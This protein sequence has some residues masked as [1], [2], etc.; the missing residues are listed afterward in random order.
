VIQGSINVSLFPI[1][2]PALHSELCLDG[3]VTAL[4]GMSWHVNIY[5][6]VESDDFGAAFCR[7]YA[8]ASD[9]FLA[10]NLAP[11][12]LSLTLHT[13]LLARFT[14]HVRL[15]QD[16]VLLT[17]RILFILKECSRGRV[18]P[19]FRAW[20]RSCDGRAAAALHRRV[21]PLSGR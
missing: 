15:L 12:V 16:F 10:L 21:L 8:I 19:P 17:Y 3:L 11:S 13:D 6:S 14:D 2:I 5:P 20:R 4:C 1:V 9:R 18:R 7:L